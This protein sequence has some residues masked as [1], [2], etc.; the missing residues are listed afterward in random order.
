MYHMID[1]NHIISYDTNQTVKVKSSFL[2]LVKIQI[3]RL[4]LKI[5]EGMLGKSVPYVIYYVDEIK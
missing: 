4:Y 1:T 3:I 5:K 2:I